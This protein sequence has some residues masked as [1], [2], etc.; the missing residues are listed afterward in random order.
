[1]TKRYAAIHAK[2]KRYIIGHS[3]RLELE[4]NNNE[5]KVIIKYSIKNSLV[6]RV[7]NGGKD[8][9]RVFH[10]PLDREGFTCHITEFS[11]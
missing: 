4:R 2:F 6:R 1:M 7:C 9:R 5:E 10:E 11:A 8:R 3:D